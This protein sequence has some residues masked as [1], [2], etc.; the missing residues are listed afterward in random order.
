MSEGK[1]TSKQLF[2]FRPSGAVDSDILENEKAMME[3]LGLDMETMV[4]QMLALS[5]EDYGKAIH[6]M[7]E[8]MPVYPEYKEVRKM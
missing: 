1:V 5:D 8:S 3:G 2:N 4:E 7:M 6:S